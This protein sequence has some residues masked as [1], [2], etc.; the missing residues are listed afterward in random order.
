MKVRQ[1]LKVCCRSTGNSVK[2]TKPS[3]VFST[4]SEE[5]W[6]PSKEAE[7]VGTESLTPA[8]SS[9]EPRER[10]SLHGGFC[11]QFPF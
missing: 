9:T 10:G 6:V 8:S 4:P 11:A 3:G 5:H 7:K 1:I 2:K